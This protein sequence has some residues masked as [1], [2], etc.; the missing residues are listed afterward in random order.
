M[1]S[2]RGLTHLQTK[3]GFLLAYIRFQL[4]RSTNN[5]KKGNLVGGGG[6]RSQVPTG[7]HTIETSLPTQGDGL[8]RS[9]VIADRD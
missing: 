6:D 8:W 2:N 9:F 1:V 3:L 4:A 7:T 5:M